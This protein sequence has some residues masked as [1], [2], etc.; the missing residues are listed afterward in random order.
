MI[1]NK[2]VFAIIPAR[3][4][5]KRLPGKNIVSLCGK[6]LIAYSIEEAFKSSYIDRVVVSTDSETISNVAKNYNAEVP[7]L[8]PEHLSLDNSPPEDYIINIL[9]Y[10]NTK[11]SIEPDII[12]ILQPTSPLRKVVDINQSL[13]MLVNSNANRIV[14]VYKSDKSP[15]W[16]RTI[17]GQGYISDIISITGVKSAD[18]HE[19]SFYLINGSIYAFYTECFLKDK[20][21]SGDKTLAY[22]MPPERSVDID[23][24]IDL[25]MAEFL[26]ERI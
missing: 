4:G 11:L 3:S 12:I 25:K 13:E 8:R 18:L 23:R 19:K 26:L 24:D 9:D 14:S 10:Y 1:E 6:P 7:F 15:L 2:T 17:T 5:S 21:I 22:I 20:S 16:Y